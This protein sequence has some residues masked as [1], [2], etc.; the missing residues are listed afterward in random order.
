MIQ[1]CFFCGQFNFFLLTDPYIHS[2][3]VFFGV[4]YYYY[5][6]VILSEGELRPDISAV[7]RV[8]HRMDVL[9]LIGRRKKK[10]M[11][12]IIKIVFQKCVP[13]SRLITKHDIVLS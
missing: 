6:G 1:W 9:L 4:F 10:I 3:V 11:Y 8:S 7:H 5:L 12:R 2:R 13:R